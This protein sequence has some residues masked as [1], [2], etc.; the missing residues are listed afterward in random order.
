[1]RRKRN[2][3]QRRT[4]SHSSSQKTKNEETTNAIKNVAV[5]Q[6]CENCQKKIVTLNE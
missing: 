3:K 1:M 5:E 6:Q 2:Y 4:E